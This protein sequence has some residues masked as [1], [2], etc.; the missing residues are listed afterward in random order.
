MLE[1]KQSDKNFWIVDWLSRQGPAEWHGFADQHSWSDGCAIHHWIIQQPNCDR[2]TAANVFWLSEPSYYLDGANDSHP[3]AQMDMEIIERWKS[4]LYST[5]RFDFGG[6]Y[7]D[8]HRDNMV[9]MSRPDTHHIP[10]SLAQPIT[11]TESYP[12]FDHGM[13]VEIDINWH[14]A[15]GKEPSAYFL[16]KN[17]L[18]WDGTKIIGEPA[19]L[20]TRSEGLER[21]GKLKSEEI[22]AINKALQT[23]KTLNGLQ[24]KRS[25]LLNKLRGFFRS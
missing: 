24:T 21:A 3:I 5:A 15:S 9:N 1:L 16:E 13:P 8:E 10:A 7:M 14:N 22:K 2:A 11:G 12:Y 17:G 6:D 18:A 4:G 25:N 19:P 20:D 23:S